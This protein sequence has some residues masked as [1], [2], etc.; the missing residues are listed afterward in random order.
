[1]F[2]NILRAAACLNYAVVIFWLAQENTFLCLALI[3]STVIIVG[4]YAALRKNIR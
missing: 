1:M 3:Y 2:R 4:D